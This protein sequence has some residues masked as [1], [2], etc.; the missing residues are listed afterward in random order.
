MADGDC[1]A[2]GDNDA[3]VWEPS[4]ETAA[5]VTWYDDVIIGDALRAGDDDAIITDDNFYIGS[6]VW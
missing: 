3:S 4:G 5:A 1:V 2:M 6:K